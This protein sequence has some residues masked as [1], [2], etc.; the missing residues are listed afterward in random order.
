MRILYVCII[1]LYGCGEITSSG[2]SILFEKSEITITTI[3]TNNNS[4]VVSFEIENIGEIDINM[5]QAFFRT[6]TTRDEYFSSI[7]G[8]HLLIGQKTQEEF[9]VYTADSILSVE[10]LEVKY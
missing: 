8:E 2:N 10:C 4:V 1:L 3:E 5:W 9:H 7:N 6:T